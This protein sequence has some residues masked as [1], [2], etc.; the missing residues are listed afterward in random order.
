GVSRH[1]TN[2][3]VDA[4]ED[5]V[6][7]RYQNLLVRYATPESAAILGDGQAIDSPDDLPAIWLYSPM[8]DRLRR[9]EHGWKV[10]E[11]FIGG[12]AINMRLNPPITDAAQLAKYMPQLKQA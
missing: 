8:M 1:A 2:H 7:V 5:G 11:R 9:T 12:S 4:D 3:I 6:V 10:F